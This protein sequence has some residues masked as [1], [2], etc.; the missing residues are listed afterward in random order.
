MGLQRTEEALAHKPTAGDLQ[1]EGYG[2]HKTTKYPYRQMKQS[3][4]IR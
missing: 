2:H 3:Y 4:M 1:K